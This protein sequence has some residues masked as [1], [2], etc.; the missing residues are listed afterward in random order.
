MNRV[1]IGI[2][3]GLLLSVVIYF[4]STIFFSTEAL[5][6]EFAQITIKNE[7]GKT[8]K[9]ANLFQN[10]G[11]MEA[12]NLPDKSAI[13]FI[14]KNAG[15]NVYGLQVTLQNGVSLSAKPVYFEHGYRGIA[16]I[17]ASEIIIKDNW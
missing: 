2:F 12:T 16:T 10:P 11:M 15:E 9:K 17:T 3:I 13:K 1:S 14:F 5:S 7:S 8:I 4:G 6:Y